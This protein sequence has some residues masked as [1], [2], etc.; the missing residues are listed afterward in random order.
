M[1]HLAGLLNPHHCGSLAGLSASDATTTLTDEVRTLRIGGKQ[2]STLFLDIKWRFDNLSP[3]TLCSLLKGK[4]VNPYLVS[5]TRSFLTGRTS[6]LC[7]QGSPKDFAPVSAC[8]PQGSPISP[9]LFVIYVLRLHCEIPHALSLSYMD[10]FGRTV[11]STS[12]RRNILSLQRHY[13]VLK[14]SGSRLG[15]SFSV[16]KTELIHWRTIRD[17]SPVSHSPVHLEGSIFPRQKMVRWLGYWFTP[18]ISTTPH[19]TMRLAK[20]QAGFVA[21]KRLSP[22]EWVF[23]HSSAT[24][25]P[26]LSSSPP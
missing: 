23:P 14:G 18:S 9:L 11:S 10:D 8:T 12:Y 17:R 4:A 7:Y 5:W 19:F 20:A 15:V 2:L 16:P 21:I 3:S 22:W 1:A 25:W 24:S 13:S 26:P 6:R